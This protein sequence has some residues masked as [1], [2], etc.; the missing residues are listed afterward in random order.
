MII[1]FIPAPLRRQQEHL[2]T[3]EDPQ[4]YLG[5]LRCSSSYLKSNNEE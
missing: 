3:A 5:V 1:L 2:G 4:Q